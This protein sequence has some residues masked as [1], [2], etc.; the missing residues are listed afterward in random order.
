MVV[1]VEGVSVVGDGDEEGMVWATV[2]KKSSMYCNEVGSYYLC[3]VRCD[4]RVWVSEH[5]AYIYRIC[6]PF[7][8]R[9]HMSIW[10]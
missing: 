2:R 5:E 3:N 6:I 8:E 1:S 4:R 7:V 10:Q 9:V